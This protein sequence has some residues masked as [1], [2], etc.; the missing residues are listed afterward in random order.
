MPKRRP[1]L[2]SLFCGPGGLDQGFHEAGFSTA[3]AFDIHKEC[4]AT[5][6]RNHAVGGKNIAH[7]YDI[8]SLTPD[9]IGELTDTDFSPIGVIGG[10]PC[11]SFSVS[12]VHQTESD[13][14]HDLSISYANLLRL[15]NSRCPISF[16]LFENVPGLLGPRHIKKF[17]HFK[18]LFRKAGFEVFERLL[19]AK[20]YGVPQDRE[21]I[22]IVGINRSIHPD[23]IWHW[24]APEVKI[25]TVRETI[26]HLPPPI[27]TQKGLDPRSIPIHPNHWTMV[28]RSKKFTTN[29]ALVEGQSWGRSFR[30]LRWDEP[31]W[32]VAYG[33]REIHVHP[34]GKRR[35]SIYEA[36]LLQSFP[37]DYVLT[38]NIS[39]QTTLVSEAVPPRLAFHLATAIKRSLKL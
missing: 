4:V 39:T 12:N 9:V 16:F 19:N 36:M 30:T 17:E 34:D 7:Q 6:N 32:T 26:E 8:K 31:S 37:K 10:P 2:L 20:D 11:Q 27:Y 21:R 28:P 3:L 23:A 13:P 22:I 5:F 1:Q 24:P 18:M 38:G 35:L 29:G 33:N 15:L 14:R 25:Q